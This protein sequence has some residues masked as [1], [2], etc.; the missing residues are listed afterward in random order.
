[1][2]K[3]IHA[4]GHAVRRR[5]V[6]V[7]QYVMNLNLSKVGRMQDWTGTLRCWGITYEPKVQG[8]YRLAHVF[9]SRLPKRLVRTRGRHLYLYTFIFSSHLP[10]AF[11]CCKKVTARQRPN[12]VCSHCR[13]M[14]AI[15][16]LACTTT[17]VTKFL[18]VHGKA[19]QV[20]LTT[21]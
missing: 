16:M 3:T 1:M 13:V 19:L 21:L 12:L 11:I 8:Q 20:L 18:A 4:V 6:E 14:T 2:V 7:C 17:W 9:G 10:V 5:G 15:L